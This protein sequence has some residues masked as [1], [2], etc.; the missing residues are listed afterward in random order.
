MLFNPKSKEAKDENSLIELNMDKGEDKGAYSDSEHYSKKSK[1][2][3]FVK[4]WAQGAK[5]DNFVMTHLFGA[6]EN[7]DYG[8]SLKD[9]DLPEDH[10]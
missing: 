3:N 8:Y 5:A 1:R 10:L 4:F 7:N 6:N 2:K 9:A